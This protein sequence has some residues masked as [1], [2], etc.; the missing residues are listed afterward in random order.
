MIVTASGIAKKK[1]IAI[2]QK[3]I[4]GLQRDWNPYDGLCVSTAV[5]YQL[6]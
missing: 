6:S 4:L 3:K 5:L 2:H 1:A